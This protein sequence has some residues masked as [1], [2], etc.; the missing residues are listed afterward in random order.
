MIHARVWK[1]ASTAAAVT[2]LVAAASAGAGA[3]AAATAKGVLGHGVVHVL[4][5][6]V[7][8][9]TSSNWSG[10]NIGV[11]YPQVAAGTTFTNITGEWTV[12]TAHQHTKGEAEFSSVWIGI[13]GGCV[14][15]DCTAT[16]S[17]LIQAGTEQ[18]VSSTGK[19]TYDAWWEIIPETSTE[20]SLPVTAGNKIYVSIDQAQ[21]PGQWSITIDNLS[22]GHTFSTTVSYSSTMATAEW[23]V[24]TPLV[25]S[26]GGG[27]TGLAAMPSI[28]TVHF[29]N[30]T[31][32]FANPGFQKIDEMVLTS[33][34]GK[35]IAQPSAPGKSRN[36]FNDCVWKTTC[37]A[38]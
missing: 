28:G 5:R 1:I 7:N 26:T 22:T 36:K 4:H 21:T 11:N 31:L 24:E 33:S 32:N 23:I 9:N 34:S 10:Y 13:G 38:P 8:T 6:G 14:T 19:A 25:V 12:P 20:V 16:D 18:D 3:S 27:P 37:A 30:A 17:S 2:A 35:V 29:R 15:S